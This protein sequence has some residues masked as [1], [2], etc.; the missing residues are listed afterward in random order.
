M[1]GSACI[2][3]PQGYIECGPIVGYPRPEATPNPS[4]PIGIPKFPEGVGPSPE[5]P[6]FPMPSSG[7]PFPD[8]NPIPELRKIEPWLRSK[9]SQFMPNEIID[10]D[11]K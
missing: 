1:P 2:R 10:K 6:K 4:A 11:Q 7:Q 8:S 9:T 3:D 5:F